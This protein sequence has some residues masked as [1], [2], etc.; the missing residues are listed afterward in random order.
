[1][2]DKAVRI[3]DT[4]S[5]KLVKQIATQDRNL[6]MA[7]SGCGTFMGVG[8][9][10]SSAQKEQISIVDMRKDAIVKNKPLKAEVRREPG[11]QALHTVST[12]VLVHR[13]TR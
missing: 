7:W 8:T 4:R 1:V 6:Q 3:Y 11:G 12:T 13:S 5:T 10:F 2:D 9:S